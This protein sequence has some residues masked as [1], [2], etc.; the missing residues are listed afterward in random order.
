[1]ASVLKHFTSGSS[2]TA[3]N[4]GNLAGREYVVTGGS[5]GIGL[6]I[7]R[8]L[9]SHGATVHVVSRV[10]DTA[11]HALAYIK[12][13]E[14][15][16]VKSS[17]SGSNTVEWHKMNFEDL[18]D[19]ARHS[20]KLSSKLDRLDGVYLIS[21]IGVNEHSLTK[22]GFDTHLTTNCLAHH[23][24][25]SHL[26]PILIK[27]ARDDPNASVRIVIMSSELHRTT[28]G[29]PSET[30]GGTKFSSVDEFRKEVGP[31]AEYSRSKLGNILFT[32]A[33]VQR[34]LYDKTNVR[35]YAT[36]PGAVA[37]GQ[38]AQFKEAYGDVAG[39]ALASVTRPL[40]RRP[41]QGAQSALFAGLS[42]D[43]SKYDNGTYSSESNEDGKESTAYVTAATASSSGS[44]AKYERP[45]KRGAL[46]AYDLAV[47][48]LERERQSQL[49]E[50]EQWRKAQGDRVDANELERRQAQADALDPEIRW[51][52]ANRAGDMSQP[53]YR[54]LAQQA[55]R[56][57]GELAILM[58]RV[59]Q[60]NVIPDI[61]PDLNP[62]AVLNMTVNGD[63]IE[64][65]SYTL[66]AHTRD[67][68]ALSAQV[69]HADE[70]LYTLLI[71]DPD[72]PNEVTQSFT[73]FAHLLVQVGFEIPNIKL[74][75]TRTQLEGEPVLRFVPPHPQN[76]TPYHRYTALLLA[77]SQP[78]DLDADAA[79]LNRLGFDVRSFVQQH[80]LEPVGV[81]FTR[82]KWDQAVSDIY[83]NILGT[84]EPRFARPPR[85][86]M[87]EGR[88]AKYE[89]V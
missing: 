61:L 41:D 7:S 48:V 75:A 30:F 68:I 46:P 29:G 24:L 62:Q 33:L 10:Q 45:L 9:F 64:P 4:V 86:D 89:I 21:G 42:G 59:T 19:V 28:F 39:A 55:W 69:Y 78:L 49:Q 43:A 66:P 54:M 20:K 31:V 83:E 67:G 53:V 84:P 12:S 25:M 44:S 70:R 82:Q 37:T 35:A 6:S 17:N 47:E 2:F 51:K 14:G 56:N 16:T 52:A 57:D 77:Q 74:S 27:T 50:L 36:H 13:D 60:M 80:Q 18:Q 88:P 15:A 38:Q 87:H 58:Q 81:T 1:M 65:G 26:V 34:Y 32:K 72:V 11:D 63:M 5:D 73:T 85:L 79:E 8:T 23:V 22:D 40:M 71:V 3:A 76:G